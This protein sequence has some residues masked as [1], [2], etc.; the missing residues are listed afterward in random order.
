MPREVVTD[1]GKALQ[2]AICLTFN[3]MNFSEYNDGCLSILLG[4]QD[5]KKLN[6]E[7]N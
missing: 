2:N 7:R 1:M 5:A 6:Y 3:I 4:E